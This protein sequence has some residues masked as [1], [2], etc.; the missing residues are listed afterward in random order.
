MD[1]LLIAFAKPRTYTYFRKEINEQRHGHTMA[2]IENI[3]AA[4]R[5]LRIRRLYNR[6]DF[7]KSRNL[8]LQ[9][10]SSHFNRD[11]AISI[12]SRSHYNQGNWQE[13]IDFSQLHI[14]ALSVHFSNKAESKLFLENGLTDSEPEFCHQEPWNDNEPLKNWYQEGMRL[15]FRY[16]KGWVFWDMP[17]EFTLDNVHDSLLYLAMNVLL[18]PFDIRYPIEQSTSRPYGSRVALSYSA[19]IDSTAAAALL[20]DDTLLAYHRR[21]FPSLL[22][23]S[24]AERLFDVWDSQFN[25]NILQIPSNHE[26]IRTSI[27]LPIGFS[28]DFAS[29]VH[30]ILLSSL[31]DVGTLAFGTPIDNTWLRKGATFRDFSTTPYWNRWRKHFAHAGLHL[32]FPINHISEAGAMKVCQGLGFSNLIN[33]CLRSDGETGCGKCWK[34]FNK[35]GP[36]GRKIHFESNEIQNFLHRNPMPTAMHALWALQSQEFED[37]VPHLTP[38][39]GQS[40]TWWENYYPPGL[41][42]IGTHLRVSVEKNTMKFLKPMEHPYPL[43]QVN[44]YP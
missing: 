1:D 6:G 5:R 42:L 17:E 19:G 3:M 4:L 37:K 14:S 41:D 44:L 38:L 20:P 8:A 18:K 27:D 31:Y 13:V 40:L 34:C 15:W 22:N 16:P 9:E 2:V 28:T 25:R 21:S 33:S 36:L 39:L 24:M 29:G 26:L 32:E 11:F 10:L 35:N 23:H 12:V 43:E 30:L 7:T